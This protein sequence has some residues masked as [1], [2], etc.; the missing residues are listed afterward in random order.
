M[1]ERMD[2]WML[3][4]F[5][6]FSTVFQSYEDNGRMVMRGCVHGTHSHAVTEP[7]TARSVGQ[8]ITY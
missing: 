4:D 8:R 7:E 6:S 5:K 3:C 2:G 1:D